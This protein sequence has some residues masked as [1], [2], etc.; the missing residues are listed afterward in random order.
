L[1]LTETAN[2]DRLRREAS[3]LSP[4]DICAEVLA[5]SVVEY[6]YTPSLTLSVELGQTG[7]QLHDTGR[8]IMLLPD[9]GAC[10]SDR[11]NCWVRHRPEARL[12]LSIPAAASITRRLLRLRKRCA[13]GYPD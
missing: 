13:H 7:G 10:R 2:A 11:R 6:T 9:P 1:T 5:L 4:N 8:G 3:L 12:L